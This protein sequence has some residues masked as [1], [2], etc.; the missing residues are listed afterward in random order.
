MEQM[1]SDPIYHF[2]VM[3]S[4]VCEYIQPQKHGVV[5]VDCTVGYGGHSLEITRSFDASDR[6]IG[7]DRDEDA[8][9]YCE[10]L[11]EKKTLKSVCTTPDSKSCRAYW[12]RKG[13]KRR[14]II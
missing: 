4:E 6:F 2:P 7:V 8:I 12:K 14:I 10:R 13:S 11:F 9:A 5:F 3:L 1:N